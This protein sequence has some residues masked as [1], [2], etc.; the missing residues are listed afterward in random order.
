MSLLERL[1]PNDIWTFVGH[2]KYGGSLG[3][4]GAIGLYSTDDDDYVQDLHLYDSAKKGRGAPGMVFLAACDSAQLIRVFIAACTKLC[5]GFTNEVPDDLA[6]YLAF[7]FWAVFSKKGVSLETAV[8]YVNKRYRYLLRYYGR[9][10]NKRAFKINTLCARV[11]PGLA[12]KAGV[13]RAGLL[14]FDLIKKT[15][16]TKR[17]KMSNKDF[18]PLGAFKWLVRRSKTA[19]RLR[20]RPRTRRRGTR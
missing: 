9:R 2:S 17:A 18:V 6:K 16:P 14:T 3:V 10:Y 19:K 15:K 20:S 4:D 1:G 11:K 7:L 5:I 13:A 8:G 12:K